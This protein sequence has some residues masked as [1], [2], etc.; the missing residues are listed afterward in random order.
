V[1]AF[2]KCPNLM[3]IEVESGNA[4]YVSENGVLFTKDRTLLVEF[5]GGKRGAY[6]IPSGVITIGS[7]AFRDTQ[8]TG[9]TIPNG[10][11]TIKSQAFTGTQLTSVAIPNSVTS[12]EEGAFY[13]CKLTSVGIG[14]NVTIGKDVFIVWSGGKFESIGFVEAYEKNNKKAGTYAYESRSKKWNRK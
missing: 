10:V 14:D 3:S 8:I 5:P 6:S 4:N 2:G 11:T 1:G 13:G 9:I 12:I 7:E